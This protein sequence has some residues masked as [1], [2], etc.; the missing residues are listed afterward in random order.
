[1]ERKTKGHDPAQVAKAKE[2]EQDVGWA[3]G[4]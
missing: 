2:D 3:I 4:G 1:M